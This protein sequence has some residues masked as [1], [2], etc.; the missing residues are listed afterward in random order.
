MCACICHTL[1][2]GTN[3]HGKENNGQRTFQP[4]SPV[5]FPLYGP[6]DHQP[7]LLP[8]FVFIIK[9]NHSTLTLTN[10]TNGITN[11]KEDSVSSTKYLF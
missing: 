8:M 10:R 4:D 3:V 1:S 2:H 5:H 9:L 7:N 6:N 11:R